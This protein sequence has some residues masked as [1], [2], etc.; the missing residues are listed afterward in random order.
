MKTPLVRAGVIEMHMDMSQGHFYA[1][2]T[3][4]WLRPKNGNARGHVAEP[5]HMDMPQE[6]FYARI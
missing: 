1:R 4:K 5:A 3:G 2:I 6:H